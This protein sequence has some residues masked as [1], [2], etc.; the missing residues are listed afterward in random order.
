[1]CGR[2]AQCADADSLGRHFELATVPVLSARY[3]VAPTQPVL[4][5]RANASGQREL[6]AL[7]WRRIASW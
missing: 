1:M 2:F 6:T 4:A 5:V 3:N 7:R